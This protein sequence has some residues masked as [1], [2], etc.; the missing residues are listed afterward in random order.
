MK[1]F[2]NILNMKQQS[3]LYKYCF[4]KTLSKYKIFIKIEMNSSILS[5]NTECLALMKPIYGGNVYLLP[6]SVYLI[7]SFVK[8]VRRCECKCD[9]NLFIVAFAI[10]IFSSHPSSHSVRHLSECLYKYV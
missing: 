9:A 1:N 10:L 2:E 8:S 3:S 6:L 5:C 4:P 7:D